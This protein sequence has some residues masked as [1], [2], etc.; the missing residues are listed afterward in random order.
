MNV[1]K[2]RPVNIK[3]DGPNQRQETAS[4]HT[5]VLETELESSDD[6]VQ[7]QLKKLVSVNN[8]FTKRK[9]GTSMENRTENAIRNNQ[10][11]DNNFGYSD[12]S[13]C[14]PPKFQ[15]EQDRI[16]SYK[17]LLDI[18]EAFNVSR[19]PPEFQVRFAA[20]LLRKRAKDWWD[21]T[22]R[23]LGKELVDTMEWHEFKDKF[24]KVFAPE[25]EVKKI[26]REFLVKGRMTETVGEFTGWFMDRA[27]FLPEYANDDKKLTK[28]YKEMLRKDIREFLGTYNYRNFNELMH[29]TLDREHETMRDV[30]SPQKSETG[31]SQR[32]DNPVYRNCKR[33]HFGECRA[34][35]N[36]CYRCGQT[37]HFSRECVNPNK[38]CDVCNRT[39]HDSKGCLRNKPTV[40]PDRQYKNVDQKEMNNARAQGR[41]HMT[42]AE[43]AKTK[44]GEGSGSLKDLPTT[45]IVDINV[46]FE[47]LKVLE[48]ISIQ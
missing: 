48:F 43:A 7:N 3:T 47:S 12:F 5:H 28:H 31:S 34:K 45:S 41:A 30:L 42:L 18:E 9:D 20:Y 8:E 32:L 36:E 2:R 21:L 37:G 15:R 23:N 35:R 6:A 13:A 22:K 14:D 33:R 24:L 27:R 10:N 19:C 11:L 26:R 38:T 40:Q 17:R 1:E 29:A 16:I 46:F 25:A 4:D 39:G 44:M